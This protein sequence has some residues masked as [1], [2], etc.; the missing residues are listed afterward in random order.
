MSKPNLVIITE[1]QTETR[2]LPVLLKAHLRGL[3]WEP[4]FPTIGRPGTVKGGAR[5]FTALLEDIKRLAR[6]HEGC[7]ISTFFDYYGLNSDWPGV[8][9]A[10]AAQNKSCLQR[11]ILIEEMLAREVAERISGDILRAGHFIPYVQPHEFEALLFA[12]PDEAA[13]MLSSSRPDVSVDELAG[14]LKEIAAAFDSCEEINDGYETAPS[15]RLNSLNVYRKG[16]SSNAH[17]WQIFQRGNLK[18]VRQN[19]P[20]FSAWL[21]KLETLK[22]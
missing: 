21:S 12:L 11:V 3:G 6:Q 7:H 15:K 22:R 9:E 2:A 4:I 14:K 8:G 5:S 10:K 19:C 16:K 1:G 17:A 18:A 20:H 13:F